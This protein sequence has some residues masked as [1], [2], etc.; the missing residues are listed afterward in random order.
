MVDFRR[1]FWKSFW[2]TFPKIARLEDLVAT[3]EGRALYPL[4]N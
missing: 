2:T 4:K 1:K 3:L